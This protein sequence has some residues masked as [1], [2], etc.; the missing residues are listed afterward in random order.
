MATTAVV[1]EINVIKCGA[2]NITS[3]CI[4]V[5]HNGRE[6]V[7][8]H[9]EEQFKSFKRD[10]HAELPVSGYLDIRV[11]DNDKTEKNDKKGKSSSAKYMCKLAGSSF[12][13]SPC[14][15]EVQ[16]HEIDLFEVMS[17]VPIDKSSFCISTQRQKFEVRAPSEPELNA[18]LQKLND[19]KRA[20]NNPTTFSPNS[21]IELET[22]RSRLNSILAH[23]CDNIT[24]VVADFLMLNKKNNDKFPQFKQLISNM[25]ENWTKNLHESFG[26]PLDF[27]HH[28]ILLSE[29][30]TG[31]SFLSYAAMMD[32][33]RIVD[34]ILT[35]ESPERKSIMIQQ[36][37]SKSG[38][39]PLHYACSAGSVKI[40]Y[41]LVTRGA[42]SFTCNTGCT[43]LHYLV[44][45]FN[46]SWTPAFLE[47]VDALVALMAPDSINI[48][49]AKNGYTP[50]DVCVVQGYQPLI[51]ILLKHNA[52]F[53]SYDNTGK[54]TL[55]HLAA[56]GSSKA[57]SVMGI[58]LEYLLKDIH[59]QIECNHQL[60]QLLDKKDNAGLNPIQH[61]LKNPQGYRHVVALQQHRSK[62][63]EYKFSKLIEELTEY[64]HSDTSV[65]PD[66]SD[67][68]GLEINDYHSDLKALISRAMKLNQNV[69]CV[70][71]EKP[72]E[73]QQILKDKFSAQFYPIIHRLFIE[74]NKVQDHL[75]TNKLLLFK[76]HVTYKGFGIEEK[77]WN[78]MSTGVEE[79][80]QRLLSLPEIVDPHAKLECVLATLRET[81]KCDGRDDE[82]PALMYLMIQI[83]DRNP[84]VRWN[85]EIDYITSLDP[86][87]SIM[88]LEG[89]VKYFVEASMRKTKDDVITVDYVET[90][91]FNTMQDLGVLWSDM[92]KES[93]ALEQMELLHS[94]FLQC[95][96]NLSGNNEIILRET[97]SVLIPDYVA[98]N[99]FWKKIVERIQFEFICEAGRWRVRYANY[100][101][102]SN[103]S[104]IEASFGDLINKQ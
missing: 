46:N 45:T 8:Y 101:E 97:P 61:A 73:H 4:E 57:F 64:Q 60:A 78:K 59:T 51:P 14:N 28:G 32:N 65:F 103:F 74:K 58:L 53:F 23:A 92:K 18:W 88:F 25:D 7:L 54:S 21:S 55:H 15:N 70:L 24:Q 13:F 36:R 104:K 40:A 62:L 10:F 26:V 68:L 67:S 3:C 82:L 102:L 29:D 72:P 86:H 69:L 80:K 31:Q 22:L 50:L 99:Y 9:T 98:S 81:C 47:Q 90:V 5:K 2:S 38:R 42:T 84:G 16:T 35:V 34:Y 6:H 56:M 37:D 27:S 94:I 12:Y 39:T 76:P 44:Q 87:S 17:I 95:A 77:F 63:E 66:I 49:E 93:G 79:A 19:A 100:V 33:Y 41:Y 30:P 20:F 11:T 1:K 52:R 83:S 91:V 96:N 89:T 71:D 85:A 75:L 48:K 43:P